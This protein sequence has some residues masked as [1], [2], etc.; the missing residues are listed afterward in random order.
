MKVIQINGNASVGST[1]KIVRQISNMLDEKGVENLIICNGYREKMSDGRMIAIGS[2]RRIKL[3]QM[4]SYLLGDAGFRS[5]FSTQKAIQIIKAEKPDVVHLHHL[6]GYFINVGMLLRFLRKEGIQTVWTMHDCW[7]FTGFCTHFD[8]IGC[9]KFERECHHCPQIHKYPYSLLLDR[10]R[11]FYHKKKRLVDG[12]RGL[13][14]VNVSKWMNSVTQRSFLKGTDTT[15][16]YNGINVELFSPKA[17]TDIRCKHGIKNKFVILGVASKWTNQKGF[18]KFL[19]LASK[20]DDDMVIILVGLD[21]EQCSLLPPN[22]IGVRRTKNQGELRDYYVAADVLL[23]LSKEETM[24]LV[25]VEAMS[26]GTPAIVCPTT[27]SPEL[28]P[29]S[30]G[31]VLPSTELSDALVAIREV[32]MR[33]KELYT[34]ACRTHVLYNFTEEKMCENYYSLYTRLTQK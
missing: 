23:N 13:H 7:P 5:S 26:C 33:T 11:H 10:S 14:I 12:W 18:D 8:A 9:N 21:E 20:I 28:V 3:N 4:M 6:E 29:K 15:V 22:I 2:K 32:K 25:T 17:E 30:C 34:N 19:E 31:I 16:I 27:A 1:G 24:G